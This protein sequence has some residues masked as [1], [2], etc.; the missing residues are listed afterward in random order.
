M[1]K[2]KARIEIIGGCTYWVI[3]KKVFFSYLFVQRCNSEESCKKRLGELRMPV[4]KEWL[5]F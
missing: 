1:E 5:R 3:Y 2:Y 4:A